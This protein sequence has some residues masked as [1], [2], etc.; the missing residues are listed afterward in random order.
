MEHGLIVMNP[1]HCTS[2]RHIGSSTFKGHKNIHLLTIKNHLTLNNC[3]G[4][5]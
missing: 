5:V 1:S 2:Q 3:L 4:C